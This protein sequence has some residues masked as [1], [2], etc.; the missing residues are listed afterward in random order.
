MAS[1]AA[2]DLRRCRL[3]DGLD[4]AHI[5]FLAEF[6]QHARADRG[7]FILREGQR[8]DRLFLLLDGNVSV[9]V[10]GTEIA[11]LFRGDFF[12]EMNIVDGGTCS[13]SVMAEGP[14]ILLTIDRGAIERLAESGERGASRFL[15]AL[16]S[17]LVE[18]LRRMDA[19][20]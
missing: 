8:E 1:V 18:R 2:S 7:E 16:C 5:G 11:R 14:C 12:G 19:R 4:D 15:L 3:F 17:A 20:W 9:R 13:A 6:C 10:G